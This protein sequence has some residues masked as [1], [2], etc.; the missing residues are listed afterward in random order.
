M[1]RFLVGVVVGAG[2]AMAATNAVVGFAQARLRPAAEITLD[3]VEPGP[4]TVVLHREGGRVVAGSDD[5]VRFRSGVL[6]R[7]GLS[8][9]DLPAF[10]G[11]DAKWRRFVTCVQREFSDFAVDVVDVPPATGRYA[12]A[13]VGGAPDLFGFGPTVGGIAP[14]EGEVIDDGVLF[15]FQPERASERSLCEVAA[16]EIGHVLGLDHSRLCGDLMSYEA[17]GPKAFRQEPAPCGEWEDRACED[18]SPTQSSHAKL[19]ELVGPRREPLPRR[20][21]RPRIA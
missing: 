10:E 21:D 8:T 7:Q 15:V 3:A 4:I 1:P 11:D 9:V 19:M 5:P 20:D 16:H 6:A 18:G 14:H 2:L 12:L 17:C 13:L